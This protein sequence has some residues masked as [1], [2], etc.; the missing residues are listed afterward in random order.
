MAIWVRRC[1]ATLAWTALAVAILDLAARSA[2]RRGLFGAI[3]TDA[4][5]V[6]TVGAVLAGLSAILL[7]RTSGRRLLAIFALAFAVGV[8]SQ[9]KLGARLQSDGFYYF[10]YARS[11]WFDRDVNF[12]NDYRMLGL[13]DKPHLFE[14]T[15]TGYAHSAWT[16]GPAIVWSPFFAAGHV[17][18]SRLSAAG[19]EVATDGTS[20]PYRQAVCLAGLFY[21][22]LGL[23]F[24]L[25]LARLFAPSGLAA[26]A[27]VLVAGGSFILWYLVREPSM[28]HAPSMAS[29]AAFMWLWAAT[30]E[31]RTTPH[32]A[33]LG[34]LAGLMT[35]VRWQNAIF[36]IL[37]I[38]EVIVLTV[39]LLRQRDRDGL[40]RLTRAASVGAVAA[41]IATLPQLLAWKA[42]YG[43]Y[44]AVSPV[45]PQ[46]R[47]SDPHLAD[48]LW[49]SRNG[50]F[51]MSPV[52]YIAAIGLVVMA[53][54]RMLAGGALTIA[55]VMMIYFNAIIQDWW[56]SAGYGGRRFDGVLPILTASLAVGLDALRGLVAVRPALLTAAILAAAVAWNG[57]FAG[58][59]RAG[60]FD[61]AAHNDFGDV[62]AAQASA[63]HAAIGH[64]F[65]MPVNLWFALRN[66]VRPGAYDLLAA[67]QF[68]SDPLRPYGR[69]DL[70]IA[71]DEPFVVG[72]FSA[73]D[74]DD[75]VT[76]RRARSGA[77]LYVALART[78]PL[79]VQIRVR[80]CQAPATMRV[81]INDVFYGP[82]PVAAAAAA[83]PGGWQTIEFATDA[84]AWRTTVN[85]VAFDVDRATA[86]ES[87]PSGEPALAIDYFRVSVP[88]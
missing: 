13:G 18:A 4:V 14:P 24:S 20:F 72:G 22:L 39:R 75:D 23:Y 71:Y 54:R 11:L 51:A 6:T 3:G 84:G 25:R 73:P 56:G 15:V 8:T 34:G 49:S 17:I 70:G 50:L 65:S 31:R 88:E 43:A 40:L 28:T 79:R 21:G 2:V 80:G 87:M 12:H 81:A 30:L 35:I 46:I 76:Y 61:P 83:D 52:L 48:I 60:A 62:A 82:L 63:A 42:I 38:C 67:N 5:G 86:C 45:G 59:M 77:L 57:T 41:V 47:W 19:S 33:A 78:S 27:T 69:I 85:R 64:P 37:P 7:A 32:W 66:G 29:V 1:L 68:L 16:I 53:R 36:G 55:L 26:A 9:L 10:A 44:F 58:A 74:A